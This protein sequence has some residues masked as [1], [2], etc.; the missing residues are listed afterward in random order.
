MLSNAAALNNAALYWAQTVGFSDIAVRLLDISD[1]AA[2]T[3]IKDLIF[4]SKNG[5]FDI[6]KRLLQAP[7]LEANVARSLLSF[8]PFSYSV[9]DCSKARL[10]E[11]NIG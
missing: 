3:S 9:S 5:H 8:C 11:F 10:Y 2:N 1:V 7:I 6:V 4:S